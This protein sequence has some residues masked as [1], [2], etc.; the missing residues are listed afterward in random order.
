MNLKMYLCYVYMSICVR[1]IV[2]LSS[3][4][5][6]QVDFKYIHMLNNRYVVA[7]PDYRY[8]F[9]NPS[10][11]RYLWDTALNFRDRRFNCAYY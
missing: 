10:L 9:A 5:D 3:I 2:V 7:L 8:P 1:I 11:T 4:R 6:F